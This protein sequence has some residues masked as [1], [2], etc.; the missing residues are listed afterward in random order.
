VKIP[1]SKIHTSLEAAPSD[2]NEEERFKR[3][4]KAYIENGDICILHDQFMKLSNINKIM[5]EAI[6]QSLYGKRK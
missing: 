6:A 5:L 2:Y 4:Q 3:A 1:K